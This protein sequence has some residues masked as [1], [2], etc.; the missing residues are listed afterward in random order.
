MSY[1]ARLAVV[2][3][4]R[5]FAGEEIGKSFFE[6]GWCMSMLR[7]FRINRYRGTLLK[8]LLMSIAATS[9]LRGGFC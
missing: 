3:C 6:G 9:G 8:A 4:V 2:F 5:L 1:C 7:I